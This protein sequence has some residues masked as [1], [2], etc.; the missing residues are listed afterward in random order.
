MNQ[1][2]PSG[3]LFLYSLKSP[4]SVGAGLVSTRQR[5]QFSGVWGNSSTVTCSSDVAYTCTL[6]V[7]RQ[8]F[9]TLNRCSVSS[10]LS[11]FERCPAHRSWQTWFCPGSWDHCLLGSGRFPTPFLCLW[12]LVS[13]WHLAWFILWLASLGLKPVGKSLYTL[14][15]PQILTFKH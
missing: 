5:Q 13:T 6:L 9:S 3:N 11:P 10:V 12:Y 4:V 14:R 7:S 2:E 8:Y 15:R 1:E